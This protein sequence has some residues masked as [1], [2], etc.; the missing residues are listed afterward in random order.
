[1]VFQNRRGL[2]ITLSVL[3]QN[4]AMKCHSHRSTIHHPS[5]PP[6]I[7][8]L[9]I[10]NWTY[11][12]YEEWT[13][14]LECKSHFAVVTCECDVPDAWMWCTR[15]LIRAHK[16]TDCKEIWW[17]AKRGHLPPMMAAPWKYLACRGG[18]NTPAYSG[19]L[20]RDTDCSTGGCFHAGRSTAVGRPQEQQWGSR[21]R[22]SEWE[23]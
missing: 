4:M 1:M 10:V 23:I 18:R 20:H 2:W 21:M 9:F 16:C 17:L 11:E 5:L 3:K 8:M 22:H 6:L 14:L 7:I 13:G 12:Y 19:E 15:C